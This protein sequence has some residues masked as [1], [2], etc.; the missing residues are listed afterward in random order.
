MCLLG[1]SGIR[2]PGEQYAWNPAAVNKVRANLRNSCQRE[3]TATSAPV[4]A[5]RYSARDAVTDRICRTSSSVPEGV[6]SRNLV[7]RLASR[8]GIAL[9]RALEQPSTLHDSIGK[10]TAL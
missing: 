5:G 10:L 1:G 2:L 3:A 7:S 4:G 8:T 6:D 9:S